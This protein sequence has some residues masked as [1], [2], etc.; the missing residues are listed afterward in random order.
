[1]HHSLGGSTSTSPVSSRLSALPPK[2]REVKA[3]SRL[4]QSLRSGQLS[5]KRKTSE[6][7]L[8]DLLK[9]KRKANRY[10][11]G[12]H[13]VQRAENVIIDG[14][15]L[16]WTDERAAMAAVEEQKILDQSLL[17]EIFFTVDENIIFDAADRDRL[18][19]EEQGRAVGALLE[20]DKLRD[21]DEVN[22]TPGVE[23]WSHADSLGAT[24]STDPTHIHT[25][26]LSPFLSKLCNMI[27]REGPYHFSAK[28]DA[29]ISFFSDRLRPSHLPLEFWIVVHN[30][31][32]P[33]CRQFFVLAS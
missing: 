10:G 3:P 11:L 9:E 16:D 15:K 22:T 24:T 21:R 28:I 32:R 33:G 25:P 17:D 2:R 31:N 23:F 14:E 29:F 8:D 6:N 26:T 1:M 4:L 30:P 19:G 20:G 13:D 5:T 27:Q 12:E 7:P 18:L